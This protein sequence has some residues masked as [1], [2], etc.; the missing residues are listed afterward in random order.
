MSGKSNKSEDLVFFTKYRGRRIYAW[1]RTE[2]NLPPT[3]AQLAQQAKFAEAA[4][5]AHADMA[6]PEKAKEWKAKADASG[7]KYLTP[8]GCAVAHYLAAEEA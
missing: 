6:N 1:E 4:K 7:D 3:D 2:S 5:L 8:F